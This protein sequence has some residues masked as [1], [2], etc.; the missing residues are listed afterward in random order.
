MKK[1]NKLWY[2]IQL[3]ADTVKPTVDIHIFD[4]IGFGGITARDFISDFQAIDADEI[5]LH[6]NSPGGSVFDGIAIQNVIKNHKATVTTYIDGIA[7]SVASII[8][9]AGD[10]IKIADNGYVMIH[11]P[12]SLVLGTKADMLKEADVLE[13]VAQ[14]A[15]NDYAGRM[16]ITLEEARALM[17]AETWWLGQEA[18]DAGFADS[19]FAGSRAAANANFDLKR[20]S[21]QAPREAIDRF[22]NFT[23][24]QTS[25]KEPQPKYHTTMTPEEIQDMKDENN[26]LQASAKEAKDKLAAAENEK[27]AAVESALKSDRE[28]ITEINSLGAKFG[29]EK[30]S[31]TFA[32]EGKSADDFRAHIL[33]KSPDDWQQSLKIKNPAKQRGDNADEEDDPIAKIE[34]QLASAKTPEERGRLGKE[35]REAHKNN[36]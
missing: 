12:A 32:K 26:R 25:G 29:F 27:T 33:N 17:A 22:T 31:E 15:A 8:A 1:M 28:R 21:A 24:P 16:G 34:K 9:L 3:K 11:D 2:R 30:E 36:P 6:I 35:L 20:F 10:E 5:A 19:T 18:V 13:K 14:G 7:G 23:P 4:K